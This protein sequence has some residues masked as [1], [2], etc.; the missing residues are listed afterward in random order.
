MPILTPPQAA[1]LAKG[2]YD[3]RTNSLTDALKTGI[4]TDGI[5][6]VGEQAVFKGKTGALLF[7]PLSKFGYVAQGEGQFAGEV[8]VALRGTASIA[9]WVTDANFGMQ[10]GPSGRVVHA[11]FNDTWKSLGDELREFLRHSNPSRIHCVGHSLGGALATLCADYCS[12]RKIAAVELYTFGCPRVGNAAF[13]RSLTQRLG[14]DAIHRVFHPADPVPMIPLFPFWHLPFGGSGLGIAATSNALI[15]G[16]AHKMEPTY[17]PGVRDQSWAS[18]RSA[19]APVSDSTVARWLEQAAEGQGGMLMGSAKVLAMIG[20]ALSWLMA[21]AGQMVLGGVGLG[22]AV[23]VTVLDQLAWLLTKA[24][25]LSK[26]VGLQVSGLIKAIFAFLGRKA[27]AVGDVTVAFL[28]WIL[29]LLFS[30][31]RSVAERVLAL[32]NV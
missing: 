7:K 11:G 26:E 15:S 1:A 2:V 8:L 22:L 13:A 12:D 5:F 14:A 29:E 21:K 28:R 3:L 17:L 16:T 4:G 19:G 10:L 24:A 27:M 23:G 18:L 30:S 6:S 25:Q 20:R 31:L 32:I 9:D